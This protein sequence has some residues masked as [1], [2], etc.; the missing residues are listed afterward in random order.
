MATLTVGDKA[1]DFSLP[2]ADGSTIRLKN[3]RGKTVVLYFYP[4][5]NTSGCTA[6]ACSFRDHIKVFAKA[7]AVVIGISADSVESHRKFTEKF[8]LPFPLGSDETKEV[9]KAYGV[10]QKKSLYGRSYLGIVRTTI[11]VDPKGIV[12]KVYSKVKVNGHV[13]TVLDDLVNGAKD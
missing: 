3:L 11:V 10:W 13:E 12:A 5:D 7:G 8:D 1:P 2:V 4:K 6:E 9:L